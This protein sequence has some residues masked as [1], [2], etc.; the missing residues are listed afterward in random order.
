MEYINNNIKKNTKRKGKDKFARSKNIPIFIDHQPLKKPEWI[1][2]KA[3]SEQ[4]LKL[5]QL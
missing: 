5:K 2:V 4:A 1:R 3:P